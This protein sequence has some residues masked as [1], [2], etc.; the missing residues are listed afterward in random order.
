MKKIITISLI[1]A[2]LL[3]ACSMTETQ[4]NSIEEEATPVEFEATTLQERLDDDIVLMAVERRNSELCETIEATTQAKFC[5]EKVSEGKLLDDA[6]DAA[7]I[8]KCEII[9]TSSISKRCEILVN[10][11]LEKIN[12][13]ARIAEQSELLITIESEGDGEECQ[14]IEDEN[15]RVQCQFNIYMTEAKASKDPS[16]CSKIEN[17]ELAEVCTSSLN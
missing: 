7:D 10:E 11:K 14:G 17:E 9:A 1:G 4:N 8:E 3:S 5:M 13:E 15:F 12:E 2:F 6:V 16:L